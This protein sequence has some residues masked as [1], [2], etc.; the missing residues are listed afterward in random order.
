MQFIF[1]FKDDTLV[2]QTNNILKGI[3]SVGVE[4]KFEELTFLLQFSLLDPRKPV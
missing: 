4:S 3:C 2:N 1:P